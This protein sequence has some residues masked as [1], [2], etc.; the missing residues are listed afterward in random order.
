MSGYEDDRALEQATEISCGIF[1]M[2]SKVKY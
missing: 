1:L 2:M